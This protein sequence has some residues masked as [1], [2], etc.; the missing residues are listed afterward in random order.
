MKTCSNGQ[1]RRMSQ[2]S[3]GIR[4]ARCSETRKKA[5]IARKAIVTKP[6][7]E[8]QKPVGLGSLRRSA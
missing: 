3:H 4:C 8:L 6:V 5:P 1:A 7:L 2:G